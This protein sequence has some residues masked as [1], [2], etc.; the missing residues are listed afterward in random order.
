M[1]E[2]WLLNRLKPISRPIYQR[3]LERSKQSVFLR[4]KRGCAIE[5]IAL[6][7][8]CPCCGLCCGFWCHPLFL[9][10][11]IWWL[12]PLLGSVVRIITTLSA[13]GAIAGEVEQRTWIDLRV[14]PI[15]TGVL[16]RSKYAAVLMRARKLLWM[17]VGTRLLPVVG[18]LVYS[19][20]F[21]IMTFR[22]YYSTDI[23]ITTYLVVAF[24]VCYLVVASLVDFGIDGAVGLMASALARSRGMALALGIVLSVIVQILQVVLIVLS[25]YV[26]AKLYA[27]TICIVYAVFIAAA[28]HLGLLYL[29]LALTI[30]RAEAIEA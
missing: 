21:Y 30:R 12:L 24:L 8:L 10:S 16:I 7:V 17:L 20:F 9:L 14:I 11:T 27:G 13:A 19:V 25:I 22:G 4:Q 15:T 5:A 1:I 2:N 26:G 29:L 6:L 23:P 18:A 3:E 28:T